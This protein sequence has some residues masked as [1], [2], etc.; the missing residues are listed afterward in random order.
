[1]SNE[2]RQFLPGVL[3]DSATLEAEH[4]ARH[5]ARSGAAWAW[6]LLNSRLMHLRAY[7][8]R[9]PPEIRN[10]NERQASPPLRDCAI[11][12][13]AAGNLS[14]EASYRTVTCCPSSAHGL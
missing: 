3:R 8:A 5:Q 1:M 10:D 4:Q 9:N 7:S 12:R 14:H 11:Q 13:D 6:L 2:T